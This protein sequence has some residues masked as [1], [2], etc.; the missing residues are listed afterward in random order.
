MKKKLK[1]AKD[2]AH[3][4]KM[5]K[6]KAAEMAKFAEDTAFNQDDFGIMKRTKKKATHTIGQLLATGQQSGSRTEG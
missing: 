1:I 3:R 4:V 6:K 2:E 5:E